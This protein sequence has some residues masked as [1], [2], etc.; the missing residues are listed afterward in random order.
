MQFIYTVN[1]EAETPIMLINKHIGWDEEDGIGIMG[2]QFQSELLAL[3]D[4][5][6]RRVEVWINSVGGKTMDGNNIYAAILNS[7]CKVDTYCMGIAASIAAV[8][9]QAG[10]TRYISDYG[11]L[12]YHPAAGASNTELQQI[13][14]SLSIMVAS[15]SGRTVEDVAKMMDRT[16][17][18]SADDAISGGFADE[19][20]V[21]SEVNKGRLSKI[22]NQAQIW[23][24]AEI[25]MTKLLPKKDKPKDKM[26]LSK[27]TNKLGLNSEANEDSILKAITEIE[28]KVTETSAELAET[29]TKLSDVTNKYAEAKAKI[30]EAENK[31]KESE[32]VAKKVKAE[33]FVKE[34]VGKRL[35]S[36]EA[37]FGKWVNRAVEDFDGTKEL[38]ESLPLNVKGV[39]T[40]Q[41][42]EG[43]SKIGSV[44]NKAMA[45]VRTKLNIN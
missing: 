23:S 25:L 42:A 45:D 20:L 18:I 28:N 39:S 2:D 4:A 37:S 44:V 19:K 8:I 38:V 31:A 34:H 27:I 6:K 33:A 12:M 36:D 7:K 14:S 26:S 30:D 15:R 40:E 3:D 5:G 13:N 1:P 22:T 43:E 16:T 35:P 41:K 17:W 10:R 29:K 11:K 32:A 24:E 9:F 21:S